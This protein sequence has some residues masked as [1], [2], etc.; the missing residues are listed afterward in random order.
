M[1]IPIEVKGNILQLSSNFNCF[2]SP[3]LKDML[4]LNDLLGFFQF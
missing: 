1:H 2:Y 4:K 3:Q